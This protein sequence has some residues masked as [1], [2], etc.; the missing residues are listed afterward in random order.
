MPSAGTPNPPAS[1]SATRALRAVAVLCAS[2]SLA[3]LAVHLAG[4]LPLSFFLT[5]FGLP[6]LF[7][8]FALAA[9]ARRLRAEIVLDGLRVGLLAGFLAT[10]VYDGV[11]SLVEVSHIFGYNGFAPILIFGSWITG[12]PESTLAAHLAGWG[13][14]YWNGLAFGIMYALMLGRRH[15]LYGLAYGIVMEL[16]MLGIF[17][18]F[19]SVTNKF[20]FIAVSMIGHLAYGAVLGL[21][22]QRYARF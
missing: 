5:V 12:Q 11:R 18:L 4:F 6:S 15:W 14:H 1:R 16:A 21:V 3:A 19:L 9:L 2:L 7:L 20:D 13:Y 17:P 22:V 10:L 8:L